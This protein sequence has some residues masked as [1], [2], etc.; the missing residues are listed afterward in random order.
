MW[1]LGILGLLPCLPEPA[2]KL[3]ESGRRYADCV[4]RY[5]HHVPLPI[6]WQMSTSTP[7]SLF[8]QLDLEK[9]YRAYIETL[10][11][12]RWSDLASYVSNTVVH[13]ERNL[14]VQ[15]YREL[16]PPKTNF[17][18]ACVVA[19]VDKKT[20]AARLEIMV[21]DKPVKELVFYQWN[22]EWKIQQVWSM[23]EG[24]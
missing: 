12:E 13:N 22:D 6:S 10:N 23:V 21:D 7:V 1:R 24:L 11:D 9:R 4:L 17:T 16:T 15:K 8:T 14:D 20:T 5:P 2:R 18:I 19:D 3:L